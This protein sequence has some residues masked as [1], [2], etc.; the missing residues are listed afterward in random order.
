M[1]HS[2]VL[3]QV[4]DP[5]QGSCWESEQQSETVKVFPPSLAAITITTKASASTCLQETLKIRPDDSSPEEGVG[6]GHETLT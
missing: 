6:N 1:V 3:Y 5:D 2:E 4:P